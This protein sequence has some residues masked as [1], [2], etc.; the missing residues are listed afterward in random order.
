MKTAHFLALK[1]YLNPYLSTFFLTKPSRNL[2]EPFVG[3]TKPSC[4]LRE[5]FVGGTKPSRNLREPTVLLLG[6]DY[7]QKQ[8]KTESIMV[9]CGT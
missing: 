4:N 9:K 5:P 1:P 2:Q 7:Y 3:G 6:I 8:G